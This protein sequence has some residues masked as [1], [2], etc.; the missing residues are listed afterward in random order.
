MASD[1]T[2]CSACRGKGT[3]R[4]R[5]GDDAAYSTVR[6]YACHGSGRWHRWEDRWPQ[7]D[8]AVPQ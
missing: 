6:C 8:R 2:I 7:G 3:R 5:V 4:R 1:S